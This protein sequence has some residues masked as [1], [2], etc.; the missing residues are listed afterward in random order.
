V[1]QPI[2]TYNGNNYLLSNLLL[3]KGEGNKTAVKLS[4]LAGL[5]QALVSSEVRSCIV[6]PGIDGL[7]VLV[8]PEGELKENP[9]VYIL[10]KVILKKIKHDPKVK[11][12]ID[13]SPV[14]RAP[15][16]SNWS[17]GSQQRPREQGHW[18]NSSDRPR[19]PRAFGN[20]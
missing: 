7:H 18:N 6:T 17:S 1:E 3:I 5:D 9:T 12:I 20:Q 16:N 15:M 13:T 11:H 8:K 2:V 10:S 4:Q 14:S 19:A